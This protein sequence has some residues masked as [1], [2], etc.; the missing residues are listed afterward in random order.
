M[1]NA[2]K[3]ASDIER[4]VSKLEARLIE[5]EHRPSH[6]L[7]NVL[8]R[9]EMYP[10]KNDPRRIAT[11]KSLAFRLLTSPAASA[12][13]LAVVSAAIL[14]WHGWLIAE[15]NDAALESNRMLARSNELL[16]DQTRKVVEAAV[17]YVAGS[18]EEP[19]D[20]LRFNLELSLINSGTEPL[21]LTGVSLD[22]LNRSPI[23]D[24]ELE[25]NAT[26]VICAPRSFTTLKIAWK[27]PRPKNYQARLAVH[28]YAFPGKPKHV[29]NR[30]LTQLVTVLA[31][32]LDNEEIG[33]TFTAVLSF[34]EDPEPEPGSLANFRLA[35]ILKFYPDEI[36]L[37][38]EPKRLRQ[39]LVE[40][41]LARGLPSSQ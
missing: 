24:E 29:A 38:T 34:P 12:G 19:P 5:Q 39:D 41:L 3:T 17:I 37:Q 36:R 8:R 14:I 11:I 10:D 6:I 4:K 33:A 26:G 40:S 9:K 25:E 15:N 20:H 16:A 22:S 18:V 27:K 23:F 30:E 1:D 32:S 31:R 13:G 21:Q 28:A 7:L 35:N 2:K